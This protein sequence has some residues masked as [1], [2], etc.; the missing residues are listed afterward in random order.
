MELE[1]VSLIHNLL[2]KRFHCI[3]EQLSIILRMSS[4]HSVLGNMH[5]IFSLPSEDALSDSQL[6]H[7]RLVCSHDLERVDGIYWK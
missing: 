5:I 2:Y 4:I 7:D 6:W 1:R 3:S